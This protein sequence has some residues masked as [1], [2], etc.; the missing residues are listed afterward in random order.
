MNSSIRRHQMFNSQRFKLIGL[1]V[2]LAALLAGAGSW[3]ALQAAADQK[4]VSVKALSYDDRV[5]FVVE[6]EKVSI[7]K[8]LDLLSRFG[9]IREL[10]YG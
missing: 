3:M 4:D 10:K 1:M 7:F 9:K 5:R 2:V 6:S 8:V